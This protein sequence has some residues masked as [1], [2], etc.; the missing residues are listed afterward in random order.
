MKYGFAAVVI[1]AIGILIQ[2]PYL[3]E[4]PA[5]IH[6]WAQADRYAIALGFLE[7]NFD[8]FHPQTFILNKQFPHWWT[9]PFENTVTS[10]DFPIHEFFVALIMKICGSTSPI[11]FRLSTLLVSFIGL[12]FL[13][14][15]AYLITD[16]FFKSLIVIIV[17]MT[18]PV[19]AYY[20]GGF[21]PSIPAFTAA[22]IGLWAYLKHYKE[23]SIKCFNIGIAF[24]A[25][26]VLIRTSFA[27]LLVA[28]LGFEFLRIL[29]KETSFLNKIPVTLISIFAIMAYFFWNAHLRAENGTLFLSGLMPAENMEQTNEIVSE[30][31]KKWK[32]H[33]FQKLHYW[34]FVAFL[35]VSI[36]LFLVKIF[37]KKI[38]K[39]NPV[40]TKNFN[41]G[42]S[43]Y[44]FIY[45][46]GSLC[47]L[48]A[49]VKQFI[50]HDYYFLDTFF[51]PL[52][53]LFILILNCLPKIKNY[54]LLAAVFVL[55]F[56]FSWNSVEKSMEM[57]KNRRNANDR[58]YKTALHFKDA[59]TFLDAQRVSKDA[60]ILALYAYPQ[61]LPFILM[62]RKGY[63]MMFYDDELLRQGLTWDYDY[64]VVQNQIF[65]EKFEEKKEFLSRLVYIADNGNISIC[66]YSDTVVNKSVNDFFEK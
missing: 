27:I 19:F 12:F 29:R 51:V 39:S 46:F 31:I 30:S 36:I 57:Q 60:C 25:L 35:S 44:I 15:L 66:K 22:M 5:F 55:V 38:D 59:K 49:M 48:V 34:V 13:Y 3:N 24:I 26:S 2:Y 16:D 32:Y 50:H 40:C 23:D 62:N 20:S 10:V 61:N 43:V 54:W 17:A 6:A 56:A 4:F 64:I 37:M 42:Y 11:V 58:S 52:L 63:T 47:F 18:S 21:I 8:F 53:L 65:R 41:F 7:N 45:L 28:T 1:V 14:K 9:F 33:Y